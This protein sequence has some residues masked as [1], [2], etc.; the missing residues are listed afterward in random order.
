MCNVEFAYSTEFYVD[1]MLVDPAEKPM[2]EIKSGSTMTVTAPRNSNRTKFTL[3]TVASA[4]DTSKFDDRSNDFLDIHNEILDRLDACFT[5]VFPPE[6]ESTEY[7]QLKDVNTK[8]NFLEQYDKV[9]APLKNV[10][11]DRALPMEYPGKFT[12]RQLGKV[13]EYTRACLEETRFHRIM[14]WYR[15]GSVA[16]HDP[17]SSWWKIVE[18]QGKYNRTLA[19]ELTE[20]ERTLLKLLP[21]WFRHTS[22]HPDTDRAV[23]HW[24]VLSETDPVT[25]SSTNPTIRSK[26]EVLREQYATTLRQLIEVIMSGFE[27]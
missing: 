4:E 14:H 1:R 10:R 22:D 15:E 12:G 3:S 27:K 11:V 6:R 21:Q 8:S 13:L 5:Y 23:K 25:C 9:I 20:K 18:N 2:Y 7:C 24:P 26:L 19:N 16:L 17:Y